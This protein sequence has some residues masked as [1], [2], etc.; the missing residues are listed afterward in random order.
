[1][2]PPGCDIY[3]L[4]GA[5]LQSPAP[6]AQAVLIF[7]IIVNIFT[8]P[9]TAVINALVVIAVKTKSRLRS[10]RSNIL[11]ACLATTDLMVGVV[12]QPTFTAMLITVS[13]DNKTEGSCALQAAIK[14]LMSFLCKASLLH[15]VVINAKHY[16]ATML[17]FEHIAVVTAAR[18][19][20][21]SALA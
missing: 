8:F 14:V 11:L 2:I 5:R 21:A 9:F 7:V 6:L 19:L 17:P 1:M 18:L 16:L 12:A 4:L 3:I 10:N 20:I 13:L 15:L